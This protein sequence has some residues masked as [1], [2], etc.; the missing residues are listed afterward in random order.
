MVFLLLSFFY[1]VEQKNV[2]TSGL[3]ESHVMPELTKFIQSLHFAYLHSRKDPKSDLNAVVEKYINEYFEYYSKHKKE[4]VLHQYK[5]SLDDRRQLYPAPKIKSH[6]DT[7]L[8]AYI[9][10]SKAYQISVSKAK[11]II[12]GNQKHQQFSPVSDYKDKAAGDESD[13]TKRK[14]RK[15]NGSKCETV[16]TKKKPSD[17]RDYDEERIKELINLI[18]CKKKNV[19]RESDT[20]DS[21]NKSRLKRKMDYSTES[22]PKHLKLSD[23]SESMCQ[24]E[25]K[26]FHTS[27]VL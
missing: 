16:A 27:T 9:F 10:D 14:A 17:P 18:Q 5:S 20:E 19:G 1:T 24:N 6:I 12:E 22:T 25:G 21:R 7:A 13:Y 26:R 4:F 3:Q 23:S 2:N 15:R 11:K 8:R